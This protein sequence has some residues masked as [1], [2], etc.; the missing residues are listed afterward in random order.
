MKFRV[1]LDVAPCS[2]VEVDRRFRGAYCLHYQGGTAIALIMEAVPTSETSVNFN[3]T[4]RRY[5]PE[6]F[7]LHVSIFNHTLSWYTLRFK[8]M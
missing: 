4:T 6:N 3:V 5:I 7:K 1:F 8:L 2:N